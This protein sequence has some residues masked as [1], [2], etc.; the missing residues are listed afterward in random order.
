MM[1]T[2]LKEQLYFWGYVHHPLMQHETAFFEYE[3]NEEADLANFSAFK[4]MNEKALAD[5]GETPGSTPDES[6][7][8]RFNEKGF[9]KG[10]VTKLP[11]AHG[12]TFAEP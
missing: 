8:Y 12:V 6:A 4:T 11:I 9:M 2:K 5:I 7:D 1:R 10:D 3:R